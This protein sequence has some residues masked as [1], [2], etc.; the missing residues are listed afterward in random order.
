MKKKFV[1]PKT[2]PGAVFVGMEDI[3]AVISERVAAGQTV[4]LPPR[5][6]SMLPLL[7]EGRDSVLL[8]PK[9]E[10]LRRYDIPLYRRDDGSYVLHRVV[11]LEGGGYNMCGDNQYAIERGITDEQIIAVVTKIRRGGRLFD[12]GHPIYRVWCALWCVSRPLRHLILR[13][14]RRIRRI[15]KKK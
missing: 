5:G 7:R 4:E 11:G 13:V 3:A 12:V 2:A 9:P 1:S 10:R 6:I 15:F 8:S 14:L